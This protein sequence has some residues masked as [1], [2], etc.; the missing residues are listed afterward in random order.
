MEGTIVIMEDCSS[1]VDDPTYPEN[2]D[3]KRYAF[4][5]VFFCLESEEITC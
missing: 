5:G 1:R 4:F 2:K 3:I